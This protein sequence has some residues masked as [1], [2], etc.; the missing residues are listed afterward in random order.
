MA[1]LNGENWVTYFQCEKYLGKEES[2]IKNIWRINLIK[3]N[4]K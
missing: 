1:S 4:W 3:A 2:I